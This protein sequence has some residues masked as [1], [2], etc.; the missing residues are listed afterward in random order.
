[1]SDSNPLHNPYRGVNAHLNS[2]LQERGTAADPSPWP[3]FHSHHIAKMVEILNSVLPSNYIAIGERSLQLHDIA[4]DN[5]L[6]RAVAIRQV[7]QAQRF[8]RIVT[9][10]ELLSP[11]NKPD[12]YHHEAYQI[13]R[14]EAIRSGI[15]LVEID[16]LH[17]QPPI[18]PGM[19]VYPHEADA[20]PYYVALTDPRPS[21]EQ[22]HVY[23]YG[24]GVMDAI[25]QI[26]VPLADDDRVLLDLNR[27]YHAVFVTGRWGILLDYTQH[28][29]QWHH[30]RADD[31][32][33]I[34]QWMQQHTA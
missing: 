1:M 6:P 33:A 18:V 5:Q 21:I 15:P 14:N 29:A 8:G 32:T 10:I 2:L 26:P 22:G 25:P 27:V 12:S 3:S 11:S 30:Y 9:R 7:T 16:Y 20:Y 34:K 23:G 24:F 31:Q 17:Q 28:P 4:D 19:P 13:N